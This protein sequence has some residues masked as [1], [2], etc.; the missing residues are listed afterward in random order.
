[1]IKFL[2]NRIQNFSKKPNFSKILLGKLGIFPTFHK[3]YTITSTKYFKMCQ[4]FF[5]NFFGI[6][7]QSLGKLSISISDFSKFFKIKI[8]LE[9]PYFFQNFSEISQKSL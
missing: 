5:Q 6:S 2:Q 3:Y 4:E 1:M 7:P 8:V 9:F